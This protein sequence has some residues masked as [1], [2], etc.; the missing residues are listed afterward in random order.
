MPVMYD[1][2]LGVQSINHVFFAAPSNLPALFL[3][4]GKYGW[5]GRIRG[6]RLLDGDNIGMS[7]SLSPTAT[8]SIK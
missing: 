2:P 5:A 1:H 6:Y 7:P 8:L 3:G 4:F